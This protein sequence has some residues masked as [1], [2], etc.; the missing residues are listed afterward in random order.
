MARKV[1]V[2]GAFD[3][4]GPEYKFI[5]DRIKER[6][7]QVLAVN[8]GVM[9]ST[10]IFTV[11]I[12][13]DVVA[14]AGGTDLETLRKANDRGQ[15]I[16]VMSEGAAKVIS[17]LYAKEAFDGIIGM[18]GT[19]GTNVV[20]SAMKGLPYG[21][22]KIC[23][24]TVASGDV[25]PYVGI[26][27][28]IMIPSLVDISGLNPLSETIFTNAAGALVGMVEAKRADAGKQASGKP[29]IAASMFGNTTP[30][31]DACREA[32]NKAGYEVLVFHATGAGGKTMEKLIEEGIIKGALDITTTEWADTLCGG[33][34][35]AG[36]SR[37]DAPGK[38]GVP[39]LIAP[40]CIDMCNFGNP[41]TIP[42]KYKDRLFYKWNPQVT[43]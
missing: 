41:D 24:S 30:C 27:D 19:A 28:I 35:D 37:L 4:K 14:K 21:V 1:V 6:N 9:G 34:F 13:A 23:V 38:A 26:S 43:L 36:P 15:A 8:T 40:G 7:I 31:I 33:V 25:S 5:I 18:G 11:D 22:P 20:T 10:D 39:H 32:M 3:T 12:Q 29:A 2:V 17:D 42:A 16:S